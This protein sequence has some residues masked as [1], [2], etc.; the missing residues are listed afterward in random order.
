A[1]KI[2]VL[3]DEEQLAEML[4]EFLTMLGHT[5][6]VCHSAQRALALIDGCDFDLILSDYRMP[7]LNGQQFYQLLTAKKPDLARRIVFLTGDL[8][9]DGTRLFLESTGN[10]HLAKPFTLA[11]V[12]QV[13]TRFLPRNGTVKLDETSVEPS[14]QM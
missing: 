9:N 11:S 7:V 5:T 2:L 14:T 10:P 8:V 3:D 4:A 12:Q 13:M 6:T 1:A